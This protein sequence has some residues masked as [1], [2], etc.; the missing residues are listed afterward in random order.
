MRIRLNKYISSMVKVLGLDL[1]QEKLQRVPQ[2]AESVSITPRT[3]ISR[4]FDGSDAG[5]TGLVLR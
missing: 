1:D 4:E 3:F 2:E 5:F